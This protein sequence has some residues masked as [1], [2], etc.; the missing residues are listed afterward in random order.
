MSGC[1]LVVKLCPRRKNISCCIFIE[2][3]FLTQQ[4]GKMRW[5]KPLDTP[6]RTIVWVFED[7]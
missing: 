6:Q 5:G 1:A 4:K 3:E 2:L 7:A